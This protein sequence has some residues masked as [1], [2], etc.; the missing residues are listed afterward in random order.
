MGHRPWRGIFRLVYSNSFIAGDA[1][2]RCKFEALSLFVQ[3]GNCLKLM[4][5]SFNIID[6]TC[7]HSCKKNVYNM[8][9]HIY[10][11]WFLFICIVT[12]V[13]IIYVKRTCFQNSSVAYRAEITLVPFAS[14][15]KK[16]GLLFHSPA[17]SLGFQRKNNI[18]SLIKGKKK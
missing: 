13:F 16:K 5:K 18:F 15:W 1:A 6:N 11:Q 17:A 4:R 9:I 2:T 14:T 8:Y 7:A 12:R 10:I 3:I